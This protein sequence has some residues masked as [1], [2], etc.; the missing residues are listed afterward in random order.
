[1][2]QNSEL[3]IVTQSTVQRTLQTLSIIHI[4]HAEMMVL[5]S[6]K[7]KQM[8]NEEKPQNVEISIHFQY[9]ITVFK[10]MRQCEVAV[11]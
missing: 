7:K 2:G 10:N 6:F 4:D 9:N 8:Y 11:T 3:P 5:V 1:M